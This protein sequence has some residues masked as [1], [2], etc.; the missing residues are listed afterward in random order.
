MDFDKLEQELKSDRLQK[1]MKKFAT[2]VTSFYSGCKEHKDIKLLQAHVFT[3]HL[4]KAMFKA[5][6]QDIKQA[7]LT[8]PDDEEDKKE[9]SI[10]DIEQGQKD[11]ADTICTYYLECKEKENITP[12]E[13]IS[14]TK[15][16][17]S[18]LFESTGGDKDE[19]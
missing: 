18:G 14:L 4:V 6:Q 8:P 3:S 7:E 9:L 1:D 16:F 5:K 15:Y 13:A 11:L 12:G 17:I 10:E 19:K 2:V